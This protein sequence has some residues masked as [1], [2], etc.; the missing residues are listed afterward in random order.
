MRVGFAVLV[1]AVVGG[2]GCG[3]AVGDFAEWARPSPSGPGVSNA[4]QEQLAG[5]YLTALGE[6]DVEGAW[7]L[8]C[9]WKIAPPD[10]EAFF[11]LHRSGL[12]RP[13]SWEFEWPRP[14]G[15]HVSHTGLKVHVIFDDGAAGFALVSFRNGWLCYFAGP[16][17][18]A[19]TVGRLDI[20]KL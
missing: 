6:G 2:A 9:D 1:V 16:A 5:D 20:P 13:V 10:R 17:D 14:G 15:R 19:E 4:S 8:L 3:D 12:P 11:E 18:Q 7:E